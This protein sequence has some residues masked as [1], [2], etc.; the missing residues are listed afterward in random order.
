M[1]NKLE[2]M[3]KAYKMLEGSNR[4]DRRRLLKAMKKETKKLLRTKHVD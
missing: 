4:P 1:S 3:A 2:S